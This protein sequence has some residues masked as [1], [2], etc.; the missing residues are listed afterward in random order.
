MLRTVIVLVQ[1]P[2]ERGG[3]YHAVHLN[4]KLQ[5]FFIENFTDSKL[6]LQFSCVTVLLNFFIN[7]ERG[8]HD[9]L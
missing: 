8:A 5:R 9:I 1:R 3:G 2:R 4:M 6:V 7:N